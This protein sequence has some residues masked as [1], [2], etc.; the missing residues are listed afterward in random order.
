[1]K[2]YA[3]IMTVS[4][5]QLLEKKCIR[6]SLLHD[7]SKLT[8]CLSD[9][10][11]HFTN[12]TY[13]QCRPKRNPNVMKY[14]RILHWITDVSKKGGYCI[15]QRKIAFF[16]WIIECFISYGKKSETQIFALQEFH[17]WD[18]ESTLDYSRRLYVSRS[19]IE[20]SRKVLNY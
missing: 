14:R 2:F 3:D 11:H 18:L 7:Y 6:F 10:A 19:R 4:H 5:L 1:M 20:K 13:R 8:L 15:I 12:E 9:V 17:L 16:N